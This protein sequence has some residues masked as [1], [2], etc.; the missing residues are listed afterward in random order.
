MIYQE[1]STSM[2]QRKLRVGYARAGRLI[3]EMEKRGIIG[4]YEGSKPRQV[5]LTKTQWLEMKMS[6]EEM[7]SDSQPEE[8]EE[9]TEEE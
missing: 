2:L 7:N 5:N 9:Q 3:D 8:K 1:A 6:N 4:Q